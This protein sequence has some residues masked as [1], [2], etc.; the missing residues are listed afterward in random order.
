MEGNKVDSCRDRAMLGKYSV[1]DA[2]VTQDYNA[3]DS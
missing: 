3:K 1:G 2:S